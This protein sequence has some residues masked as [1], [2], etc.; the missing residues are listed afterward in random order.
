MI[1]KS[2]VILDK[3]GVIK[4]EVKEHNRKLVEE[5]KDFFIEDKI[6]LKINR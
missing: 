4:E 5:E 6:I 1:V 3:E 2:K